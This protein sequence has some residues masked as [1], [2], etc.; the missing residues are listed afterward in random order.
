MDRQAER[1]ISGPRDDD[2]RKRFCVDLV[3]TCSILGAEIGERQA[4]G[5]VLWMGS[6]ERDGGGGWGTSVDWRRRSSGL[7]SL[8]DGIELVPK[9]PNRR[10]ADD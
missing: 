2:E 9:Q 4:S 8:V 7:W 5:R 1:R 6:G 10:A 3:A